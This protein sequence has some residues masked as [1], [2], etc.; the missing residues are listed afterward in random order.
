MEKIIP[1]KSGLY[2]KKMIPTTDRSINTLFFWQWH[3][4]LCSPPVD[5]FI[6]TNNIFE[7]LACALSFKR[8]DNLHRSE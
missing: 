8:T 4:L 3:Q 6:W 2:N 5:C 1:C 7:P